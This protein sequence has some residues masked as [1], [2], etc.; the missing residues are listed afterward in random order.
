VP[1][2]GDQ[3]VLRLACFGDRRFHQRRADALVLPR[4]VDADRAEPERLVLLDVGLAER[5]VAD[6]RLVVGGDE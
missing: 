2:E 1:E 5:D 3:R 4:G 6:D